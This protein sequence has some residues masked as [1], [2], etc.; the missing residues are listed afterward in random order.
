MS[1][2]KLLFLFLLF[3][4]IIFEA[5]YLFY[6]GVATK[7]TLNSIIDSSLKECQNRDAWRNCY[8]EKIA[9]ITKKY[10]FG[11]A[12]DAISAIQKQDERVNDC[13]ILAHY[14]AI[15]AV[16]KNP[17]KWK[18]ILKNINLSDCN[19]GY[20]HGALEG[21]S[22]VDPN[23]LINA[24]S[25]PK[26]CAQIADIKNSKGTDQGCA[27]IMGHL[28]LANFC[29]KD[30]SI[31]IEKAVEVCNSVT[32]SL[33]HE[34][35]AGIFMESFT[36]DNLATH[37]ETPKTGWDEEFIKNQE[38]ICRIYKNEAA[39]SCW[40]EISHLYNARTPFNPKAVY[41]SCLEAKD[42]EK[43]S[44]C[45]LHAV[46]TLIR[47]PEEKK[48]LSSICQP[49]TNN[50]SLYHSCISYALGSLLTASIN[51]LPRA[52]L[53]CQSY[54]E[55]IQEECFDNIIKS[56]KDKTIGSERIKACEELPEKYRD[57]CIN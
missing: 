11:I 41:E 16:E 6:S 3:S 4:G 33:Q 23:F 54:D 50:S 35:Y 31:S 30:L 45:Y 8:G 48:Y 44:S 53:F 28:T 22:R 12:I 52:L 20:V 49:V 32:N 1:K 38:G 29:N 37:C 34:C 5:I 19:Y 7:Q 15:A 39:T 26:I 17:G 18:D 40:Q 27:H 14:A 25:I 24:T 2:T 56:I 57:V 9:G 36:R 13:H 46:A 55:S 21:L 42:P 10:D 43:I 47:G 51:A